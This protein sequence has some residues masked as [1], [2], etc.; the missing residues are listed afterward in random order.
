MIRDGRST[1]DSCAWPGLLVLF[2]LAFSNTVIDFG[3]CSRTQRDDMQ[4]NHMLLPPSYKH[5]CF[6]SRVRAPFDL[7]PKLACP[8]RRTPFNF[9]Q[10]HMLKCKRR[11]KTASKASKEYAC[12]TLAM[13]LLSRLPIHPRGALFHSHTKAHHQ[14]TCCEEIKYIHNKRLYSTAMNHVCESTYFIKQLR[15]N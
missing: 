2:R 1:D 3:V 10:S 8:C 15:G 7:V 6:A 13:Q 11:V 4:Q 9:S 5:C 14:S 12:H